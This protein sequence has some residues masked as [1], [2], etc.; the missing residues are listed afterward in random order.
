MEQDPHMGQGS[1]TRGLGSEASSMEPSDGSVLA[2]R[3]ILASMHP[4]VAV[5]SAVLA[6]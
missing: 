3:T 4:R 6:R 2:I 1:G 5:I